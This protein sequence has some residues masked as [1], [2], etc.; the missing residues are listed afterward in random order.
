MPFLVPKTFKY[1]TFQSFDFESVPDGGY[2]SDASCA[3]NSIS[4]VLFVCLFAALLF[5]LPKRLLYF[6]ALQSLYF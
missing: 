4:T 2:S 6:L 3:L 5:Y 1:L